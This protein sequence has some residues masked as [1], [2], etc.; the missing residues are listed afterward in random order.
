M[1][2][3]RINGR[4]GWGLAE[5]DYRHHGGRP[6]AYSVGDPA[7]TNDLVKGQI[8]MMN[9]LTGHELFVDI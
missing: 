7:W 3:F 8:C 4:K 5:W 2:C 9:S 1:F 6:R